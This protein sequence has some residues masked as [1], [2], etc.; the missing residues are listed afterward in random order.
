[1]LVQPTATGGERE[2]LGFETLTLAPIDRTLIDPA[3]LADPEIRANTD[4]KLTRIRDRDTSPTSRI[5]F[6]VPLPFERPTRGRDQI[7][8]ATA[9]AVSVSGTSIFALI[10]SPSTGSAMTSSRCGGGCPYT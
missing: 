3:L 2:T 5:F 8:R 4:I 6:Q 9:S 1:V 7:S 10:H